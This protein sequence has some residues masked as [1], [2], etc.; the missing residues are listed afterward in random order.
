MKVQLL[1][2]PGCPNAAGAR[3]ALRR[4][5]AKAGLPPA[6]EEVDVT[7]PDTPEHLRQWGSPTI[8]VDGRD[9]AGEAPM[10]PSCR[11]YR[12]GGG[13]RGVPPDALIARALAEVG[14]A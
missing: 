2:F 14:T 11:I 3:E 4:S 6:F 1:S 8:L 7:A 12:A 5:L 13:E 9:V 10:G